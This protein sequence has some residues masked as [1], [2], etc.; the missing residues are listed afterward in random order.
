[1]SG[2]TPYRRVSL[3]RET[4]SKAE[5]LEREVKSDGNKLGKK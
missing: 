4:N 5:S 2:S 1:M 3:D